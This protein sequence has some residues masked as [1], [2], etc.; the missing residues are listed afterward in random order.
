VSGSFVAAL[1]FCDALRSVILSLLL[2]ERKRSGRAKQNID[3]GTSREWKHHANCTESLLVEELTQSRMLDHTDGPAAAAAGKTR[4]LEGHAP[5][6][7][8]EKRRKL[9]ERGVNPA[10]HRAWPQLWC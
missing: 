6:R 1:P 7:P 5:E 9:E 4:I 8:Q 3:W 2:Q 10:M